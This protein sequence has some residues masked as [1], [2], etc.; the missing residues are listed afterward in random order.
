MYRKMLRQNAMELTFNIEQDLDASK[1]TLIRFKESLNHLNSTHDDVIIPDGDAI[2]DYEVFVD[3]VLDIGEYDSD[4]KED[5]EDGNE[6]Q[7]QVG[8]KQQSPKADRVFNDTKV[9]T[10]APKPGSSKAK[11]ATGIP[12]VAV[13]K[14]KPTGPASGASKTVLAKTKAPPSKSDRLS[15]TVPEYSNNKNTTQYDGT[16]NTTLTL[17]G[18]LTA[19]IQMRLYEKS[20]MVNKFTHS[21]MEKRILFHNVDFANE[22]ASG[23]RAVS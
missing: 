17:I 11:A 9:T 8:K 22:K 18:N 4:Y 19:R 15:L 7:V 12:K 21:E 6:V 2:R 5:N 20:L 13:K 3:D 10:I 23:I 16:S 1:N 14:T